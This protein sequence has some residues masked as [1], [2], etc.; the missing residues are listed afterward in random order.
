MVARFIVMSNKRC[1]FKFQYYNMLLDGPELN[2]RCLKP[3]L[4]SQDCFSFHLWCW[5]IMMYKYDSEMRGAAV[6]RVASKTKLRNS[7]S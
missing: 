3:L 1:T 5:N 7:K 6:L 4:I 2:R